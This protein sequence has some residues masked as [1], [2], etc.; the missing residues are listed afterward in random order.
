MI[1]GLHSRENINGSATKYSKWSLTV[2]KYLSYEENW[3]R[4]QTRCSSYA[5]RRLAFAFSKAKA[6]IGFAVIHY[7]LHGEISM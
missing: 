6:R 3:L 5:M 2:G 1:I 4:I 7:L